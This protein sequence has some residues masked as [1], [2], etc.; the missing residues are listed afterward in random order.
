MSIH[1]LH[2][3]QLKK[4]TGGGGGSPTSIFS[5]SV[6]MTNNDSN[7]NY[8]FRNIITLSSNLLTQVR[9][10]IQSATATSLNIV[11][12]SFGKYADLYPA[13]TTAT[14][15]PFLFSGSATAT[16]P[17]NSELVSDWLNVSSLTVLSGDEVVVTIDCGANGGNKYSTGN[18]NVE[19]VFAAGAT[20]GLANPGGVADSPGGCWM[21]KQLE[22]Q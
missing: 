16:V 5:P 8:S 18:T 11:G 12:A 10:T 1:L 14:P 19:A 22:T 9:V 3:G 6:T 15:L 17:A 4:A 7:P 2:F 21:V 20:S 13:Q